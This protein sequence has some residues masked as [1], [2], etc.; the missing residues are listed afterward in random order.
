M[1]CWNTT[2]EASDNWRC[3]IKAS[4]RLIKSWLVDCKS[5]K[6]IPHARWTASEISHRLMINIVIKSTLLHSPFCFFFF[7]AYCNW[8]SATR[9]HDSLL[10]TNKFY[11][12]SSDP[13]EVSSW[14]HLEML[15]L[16][17]RKSIYAFRE[18]I[19]IRRCFGAQV[20]V[21]PLKSTD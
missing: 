7:F 2:P 11:Q 16:I 8:G 3:I 4:S 18:N 10:I 6:L 19:T 5:I 12:V 9:I 1:N 13:G 21:K 17:K 20:S 15:I 14:I